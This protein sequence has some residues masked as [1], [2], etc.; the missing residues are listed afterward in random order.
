MGIGVQHSPQ[1]YGQ[2]GSLWA[3][4]YRETLLFRVGKKKE[5]YTFIGP[6]HSDNQGKLADTVTTSKT[7]VE[8]KVTDGKRERT[9]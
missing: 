1:K 8:Q 3:E 7:K 2:N 4:E 9:I 6:G 5:A